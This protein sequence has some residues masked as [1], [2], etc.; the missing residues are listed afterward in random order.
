M[1]AGLG[2][3]GLLGAREV[4]GLDRE[5]VAAVLLGAREVGSLEPRA[6]GR[7]PGAWHT[8]SRAEERGKTK[9]VLGAGAAAAAEVEEGREGGEEAAPPAGGQPWR[10]RRRGNPRQMIPY[11]RE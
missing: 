10:R 1:V 2:V 6:W 5:G 7:G 11:R 8:W 9:Q 3:A 4:G